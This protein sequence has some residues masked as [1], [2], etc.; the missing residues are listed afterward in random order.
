[1]PDEDNGN[2][3]L[4]LKEKI[5]ELRLS[6]GELRSDMARW[7]ERME[8]RVRSLEDD[9]LA[10]KAIRAEKEKTQPRDE[11]RF[12]LWPNIKDKFL[13]PALNYVVALVL[14]Y[15]FLRLTGSIP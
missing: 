12:V 1:M 6:L 7:N 4:T 5:D 3:T 10:D 14:G 13:L 11:E 15:L 2:K 8:G 9:R